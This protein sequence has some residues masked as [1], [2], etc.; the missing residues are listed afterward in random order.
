[1]ASRELKDLHPVIQTKAKQHLLDC[2]K[3]GIDLLIYCTYRSGA[4]QDHL[5]AQGRTAPGKIVTNA[6]AGQSLHNYA[7][8]GKPAS[9]A[10][11]CVPLKAGKPAWN[12]KELYE[13][14][15]VIGERLG[16]EWA[17]RWK[18]FKESPHFQVRL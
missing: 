3:E 1:M 6:K 8:Q 13:R 14:V 10:Y 15:G 4:E 18:R 16:L 5:Y 12:D 17:G 7:L 9:L 2:A 11:D